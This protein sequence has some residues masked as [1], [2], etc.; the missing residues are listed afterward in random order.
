[1]LN[2]LPIPMLDGG[3]LMYYLVEIIK[4]SP[5]SAAVED[6]GQRVGMALL[7]LLMS[8]ALYNDFLRL[9]E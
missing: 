8:I 5:V 3:H 4:G 9:V 1:V 2:L 7:L 6:A